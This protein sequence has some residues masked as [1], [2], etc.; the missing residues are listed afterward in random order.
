M[1]LSGQTRLIIEITF[2]NNLPKRVERILGFVRSHARVS[3]H[4]IS[5]LF[6]DEK[7]VI[8]AVPDVYFYYENALNHLSEEMFLNDWKFN[9]WKLVSIYFFDF[10][11]NKFYTSRLESWCDISLSRE[12][13]PNWEI[14]GASEMNI[15][16]IKHLMDEEW[17]DMLEKERKR[18]EEEEAIE[19]A[20][21]ERI[22]EELKKEDIDDNT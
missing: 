1:P 16:S 8:E 7:L 11:H 13:F 5:Y 14:C 22:R 21:A 15:L 4:G 3:K 2:S 18:Q 10:Y 12:V 19:R 6:E 17:R 20:E 9:K